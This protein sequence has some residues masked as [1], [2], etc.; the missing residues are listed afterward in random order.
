MDVF[1]LEV[2]SGEETVSK[3]IAG[4]IETDTTRR[5]KVSGIFFVGHGV[6]SEVKEG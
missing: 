2:N 6:E 4:S 1:F 3:R 5:R